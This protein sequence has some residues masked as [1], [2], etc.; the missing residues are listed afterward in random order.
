MRV[1]VR[2]RATESAAW[3]SPGL[4]API[5]RTVDIADRCP[6]CGGP[7]GEP[8]RRPF[9]EDGVAFA[10]DCWVNPCGHVDSYAAVLQEGDGH[11]WQVRTDR[12]VPAS[13][14]A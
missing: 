1:T 6:R 2:D 11:G 12:G 4:F 8:V 13:K 5:V 3:G 14:A 7:R 10:V 9:Y